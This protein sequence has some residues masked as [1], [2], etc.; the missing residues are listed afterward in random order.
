[1][2]FLPH[3]VIP[4]RTSTRRAISIGV[5]APLLG[6]ALVACGGSTSE[7]A[8]ATCGTYLGYSADEKRDFLRDVAKDA[9]LIDD[10]DTRKQIGKASDDELD[11]I[12]GLLQT[13]CKDAGKDTLVSELE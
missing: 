5:V 12:A 4:F 1:M 9:S 8:D 6:A 13:A 11:L 3:P 10:A 7:A 2:S